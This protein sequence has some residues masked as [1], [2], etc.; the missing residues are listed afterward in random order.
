[1]DGALLSINYRKPDRFKSSAQLSTT[2]LCTGLRV[3][4]DSAWVVIG[5]ARNPNQDRIDDNKLA[6]RSAGCS[7][8]KVMLCSARSAASHR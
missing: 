7:I 5:G 8:S 1:M 6:L 3:G 4:R 2:E